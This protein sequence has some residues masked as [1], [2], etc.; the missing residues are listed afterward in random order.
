LAAGNGFDQFSDA[1]V[2]YDRDLAI[3]GVNRAAEKLFGMTAEEMV[4]NSCKDVFRCAVC[5]PD[6]G[7]LVGF[8]QEGPLSHC[9]I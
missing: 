9:T 6:C 3:T 4:G 5:D 1:L 8:N 7:V 2:L